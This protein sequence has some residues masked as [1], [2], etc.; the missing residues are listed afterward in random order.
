[1][2]SSW[3][4]QWGAGWAP[5]WPPPAPPCCLTLASSSTLLRCRGTNYRAPH[6]IPIDLLDRLLI[7]N[8]QPYSEKEIRRILDIRWGRGGG[9]GIP[10]NRSARPGARPPRIGAG[11]SVCTG[12]AR[13]WLRPADM[14]VNGAGMAVAKRLT[15]FAALDSCATHTHPSP[16]A[17]PSQPNEMAQH[18]GGGCGGDRRRQGPADQDRG[19]GQPAVGGPPAPHA[20]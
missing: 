18:R 6:G 11:P 2:L 17:A 19:G 5:C 10:K 15:L 1:M 4:G 14:G 16:A 12:A 13:P 9:G 3:W 8:T 7:I 20:L